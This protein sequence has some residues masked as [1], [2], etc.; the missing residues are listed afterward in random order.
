MARTRIGIFGLYSLILGLYNLLPIRCSDGRRIVSLLFK[1][2]VKGFDGVC[3]CDQDSEICYQGIHHIVRVVAALVARGG[4]RQRVGVE[5]E[6][7]GSHTTAITHLDPACPM[8]IRLRSL[9]LSVANSLVGEI[10]ASSPSIT[11]DIDSHTNSI[12][13]LPAS[14]SPAFVSVSLNVYL[15]D[16]G[17]SGW[18]RVY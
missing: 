10:T 18:K 6:L 17:C 11:C 14:D 3:T 8:C 15:S 7:I 16:K 4:E 13:C 12:L 5:V 1:N 9:L 2:G